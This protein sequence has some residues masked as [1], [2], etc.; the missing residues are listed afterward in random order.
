MVINNHSRPGQPAD[1]AIVALVSALAF[2]GELTVAERLPWGAEGRGVIAVLVGAAAAVAITLGRGGRLADLGFRR[3]KRWLTVPAWVLG[4]LVAFIVA[5]NAVPLLVAPFFDLPEPDLSRYDAVRGNLAAAVSLAIVL[6][7]TA[8]I[9]E[10]ILYRGF[11]IGRLTGLFGAYAAAPVLAVLVQ[12]V[13][14]GLVHFQWGPGG[15]VVTAIMG[16]VWGFAFLLCGRNLWIVIIAHSMA[17][18]ALLTQLY[19]APPPQ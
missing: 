8:A 11:L 15:I 17:H 12:A 10:E 3:P 16:A 4:I 2:L 14:F 6:P 1:I 9:P 13:V 5:Q 19:Q 18:V 7:L